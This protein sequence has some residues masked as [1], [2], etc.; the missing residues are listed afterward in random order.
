MPVRPE[1]DD[2]VEFLNELLALDPVFVTQLVGF[3]T[4]CNEAIANHPSVQVGG[5]NGDF[6]AGLLGVVNGFLGVIDDGP[7][8]G[9]G[10]ITAIYEG[11][12][13]TGFRRTG[14]EA[15]GA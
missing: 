8:A 9:W 4:P 10:P 11:D 3:R 14:V 13:L 5:A 2:V 1:A 6:R 12:R 7:K 15:A